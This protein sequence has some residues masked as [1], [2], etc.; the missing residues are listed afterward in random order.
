M[1]HAGAAFDEE[2][3]DTLGGVELVAGEREQIELKRFHVDGNF[4][5]GLH[6][7]GVEIDVGFRGDAANLRERLDGAEFV[8]GVHDGDEHGFRA[9]GL[10]Q[11]VEI[12]EAVA[13]HGEIGDG[14][15]LFF[16]SLAGIED[17]FVF[18][19][20]GDDVLG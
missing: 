3:T 12:N 14:D 5:G 7:V 19:G 20:G 16:E 6:G 15:T 10:A 4:S 18:D 2:R 17:G 1:A 9:N 8:V 11:V 13:I